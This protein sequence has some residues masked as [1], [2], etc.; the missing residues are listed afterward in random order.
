MNIQIQLI[1]ISKKIKD[2]SKQD[3]NQIVARNSEF[4]E[5]VENMNHIKQDMKDIASYGTNT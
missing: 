3:E 1:E 4:D 2:V 5:L